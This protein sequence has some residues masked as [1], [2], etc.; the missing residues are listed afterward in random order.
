MIFGG[1]GWAL[2]ELG[3]ENSAEGEVAVEADEAVAVE[4]GG[5]VWEASGAEA[6]EGSEGEVEEPDESAGGEAEGAGGDAEVG[7]EPEGSGAEMGR[8]PGDELVE[9]GL[10]EAVEEEVGDDEVEGAVRLKGAGIG[11]VG[12]EAVGCGC[13]SLS[14]EVEHLR[15][16]VDGDGVEAGVGCQQAGEE[17]A[18]AVAEDEGSAGVEETGEEVEAAALEGRSESE[19]LEPAVGAGYA[20]EVWSMVGA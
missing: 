10:G 17:A 16:E 14:E 7:E 11:L 15:A 13:G 1:Q 2:P 8:E 6:G 20:V 3:R 19:V 12:G 18:S 5:V 4:S 9:L